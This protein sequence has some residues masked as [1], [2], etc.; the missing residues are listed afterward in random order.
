[1]DWI[2]PCQPVPA[3]SQGFHP[4]GHNGIDL[5]VWIGTPIVAP[6]DGVVSLAHPWDD[7][8]AGIHLNIDHDTAQS[9]EFHCSQLLVALGDTVVQ[10]QPV[11]LSGNTGHSTGPHLHYEL[12][13]YP[14]LTPFDPTPTLNPYVPTPPGKPGHYPG[15]LDMSLLFALDV[16]DT[17]QIALVDQFRVAGFP[18]GAVTLPPGT[19][20]VVTDASGLNAEVAARAALAEKLAGR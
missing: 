19:V 13:A 3:V 1:M 18:K 5:A 2:S 8:D 4:P 17:G 14:G 15:D 11:A 6:R 9:R 16:V 20:V 12:R 10:G 7:N